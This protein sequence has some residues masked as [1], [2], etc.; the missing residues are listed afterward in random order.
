MTEKFPKTQQT[1]SPSAVPT[2]DPKKP[3]TNPCIINILRIEELRIPIALRIAMSFPFSLT[4]I[5]KE[6]II[7]KEATK[8][9]KN[10][11]HP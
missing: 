4:K 1:S 5:T 11:I 8:V 7:L 2:K 3:T 9:I 10:K 6:L